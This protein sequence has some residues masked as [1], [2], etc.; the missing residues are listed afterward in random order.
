M[1]AYE[2]HIEDDAWSGEAA[3]VARKRLEG[4]H[5]I[6]SLL[7]ESIVDRL[8]RELADAVRFALPAALHIS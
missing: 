1:P 4:M 7:H 8:K 5:F 6:R 3:A 2:L